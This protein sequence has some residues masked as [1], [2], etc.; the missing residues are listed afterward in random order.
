MGFKPISIENIFKNKI[1]LIDYEKLSIENKTL[2]DYTVSRNLKSNSKLRLYSGLEVLKPK[3]TDFFILS[4]SDIIELKLAVSEGN[5]FEALKIVYEISDFQFNKI[6]MFNG[7]SVYKWVIETL[8]K[9]IELET[10]NLAHEYSQEELNA[11]VEEL[12]VFGYIN[13][14]DKMT[15]GNILKYDKYLKMPYSKIFRKMCLD[16][17][18]YEITKSLQENASRKSQTNN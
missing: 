15:K 11:G 1:K 2:I 14:L 7:F 12:Q 18:R 3:A 4:W 6:E 16:K 9:V 13:V 17:T 5:I 10:E 8:K